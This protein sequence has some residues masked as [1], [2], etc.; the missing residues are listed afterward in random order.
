M[1]KCESCNCHPEFWQARRYCGYGVSI[2]GECPDPHY[3]CTKWKAKP[4][5]IEFTGSVIQAGKISGGVLVI[6]PVDLH[7]AQDM[8]P[9][10]RVKV[11]IEEVG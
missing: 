4:K 2:E 1:N 10:S 5:R 7:M 9:A 8:T 11:T 3:G 6:C